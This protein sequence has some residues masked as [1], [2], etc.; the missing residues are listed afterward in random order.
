MIRL[1]QKRLIIPR[2][3]T[4]I[5]SLPAIN[6]AG[7]DNC[8]VFTIIDPQTNTLVTE[9]RIDNVTDT[10]EISLTHED[11]VNLPIG[12]FLWD[13][14]FYNN[15]VFE[16]GK[17]VSGEEIDSYYAAYKMPECEI[18]QTGDKLL[19]AENA[20]ST[21]LTP[22]YINL[23]ESS[24]SDITQIM[25]DTISKAEEIQNLKV[26]LTMLE[27]GAAAI[28]EYDSETNTLHLS[29]PAVEDGVTPNLTIGTV[30]EGAIASATITGTKENPIL[31]LTLPNANVPTKVSQLENDSG[32][33]T[34]ETDPT[35]PQWAKA[36]TKP[37]Y[38]PQ[39]VGALP[40]DTYIPQKTSDL[41]N[42]SN[43]AADANYVHT[44]NNY[45]TEE[46]EKLNGIAAGAEVNV[47]ADWNAT[48]GDAQI[49]NKPTNVS[50]FTNDA[51]YLTTETDPT[52][53]AWA[54]EPTKPAYTA[55]EVGA[56]TV[57]EMQQA[58]ANV[59]TM[60]IHI[61]AQA[62]Y[63]AETGVP[64]IQNPDTQTF[65]L[66][67][68]GEGSNLFIEWVYVN[69]AWE[70]FGSADVEVPVTDVQ[71]NGASV[72]N[73]GVANVPVASTSAY[74]VIKLV[75]NGGLIQYSL[76][77]NTFLT[78]DSATEENNKNGSL[79]RKPISPNTINSAVFYGL[80]KAAGDTTQ[81]QSDNPV[82]Q[83]TDEAKTAIQTMLDVP[84]KSDIP[85]VPVQDVQVNGVSVVSGGVANVPI[86][87]NGTSGALGVVKANAAIYGIEISNAGTV[88]I[89]RAGSA[90]IKAGSDGYKPIAPI[91]QHESTF[92]G[93]AKAAGDTTQSASSNA[94]GQ[95]TESAKSAISEMLN[96]SVAVSGTTP[97]ITALP[98]I[99][100]VC[101]EV[102]T[103]DIVTP[104]SGIVDIVFTSGA[105]AAVLTVT[106]P[107][108]MTM[109]WANGFDPTALE[110]DT[111][112]EINIAD[113]CLGVAASWT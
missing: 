44:D 6:T 54:K 74:G 87:G 39:E 31:N 110:A 13:I 41:T 83:Y 73:N 51:G 1:V 23:V 7:K 64:T 102:S 92:Y 50:A 97:T 109:K 69:N 80:A 78:I 61:C 4:G 29:L 104:E 81:S 79:T 2:G 100:Y 58:I 48:S 70:R 56:P 43:Y 14:K 95:Y 27:H 20:A 91:N 90:T 45:T 5:L 22:Y 33:L 99:R 55:A 11:T 21:T 18:R 112:Y 16:D 47:N 75:G 32:Y 17:L 76:G 37:S 86:A 10:I 38:T 24:L 107:S 67:P 34:T 84:A 35:V 93:L 105:T 66:V 30:Q 52:V 60:K 46:K 3:D 25:R 63:N 42:D 106:P 68:G 19:T 28:L 113:G 49:L 65:Y 108:G 96:G 8:A 111:T 15:P 9:K 101:G 59:N 26:E 57:A 88:F 53:P 72:L 98:G 89:A 40:A 12:R 62:E 36:V 85:E 82:G 77:N 71:V 103:I 94:V